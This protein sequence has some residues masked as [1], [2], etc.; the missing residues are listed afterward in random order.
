MRNSQLLIDFNVSILII[1][2]SHRSR[3][4]GPFYIL[5]ACSILFV[6]SFGPSSTEHFSPHHLKSLNELNI[7]SLSFSQPHRNFLHVIINYPR[8]V[9]HYI[10]RNKN[11][12]AA[13]DD[14]DDTFGINYANDSRHW[15]SSSSSSSSSFFYYYYYYHYILCVCVWCN[16]YD[17]RHFSIPFNDV[18]NCSFSLKVYCCCCCVARRCYFLFTTWKWCAISALGDQSLKKKKVV[19]KFNSFFLEISHLFF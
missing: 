12:S 1:P 15:A 9:V 8:V 13:D 2:R 6:L 14:D 11:T 5:L 19:I 3:R 7:I 4:C 10:I 16:L 17:A 18:V